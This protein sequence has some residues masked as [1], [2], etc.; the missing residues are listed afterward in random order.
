MIEEITF[1]KQPVLFCMYNEESF[2]IDEITATLRNIGKN[3]FG[4]K[5]TIGKGQFDIEID[6]SFKGFKN[7]DTNS[8]LT[9]SPTILNNQNIK[10]G[11]YNTFNRFGK[12]VD[13]KSPFKKSILMADSGAVVCC[14][15][16]KEYIGRAIDNGIIA[17]GIKR[18]SFVQGYSILVPF[19]FDCEG[20]KDGK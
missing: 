17:N 10:N 9:I 19:K 1:L 5:S 3:G 2:S 11:Y 4:K 18:P 12:Y 20:L 13:S 8:Y 14:D 6:S 16:K 7:I 15:D